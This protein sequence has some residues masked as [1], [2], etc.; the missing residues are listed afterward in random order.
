MSKKLLVLLV[1]LLPSQ[2]RSAEPSPLV[3]VSA[4]ITEKKADGRLTVAVKLRIGK[5]L[6]LFANP[7]GKERL[8]P[9]RIDIQGKRQL[10]DVKVTYPQGKEI[11][12]L[13]GSY[14]IYEGEVVITVQVRRARGDRGPLQV[15]V[16]Y[17]PRGMK[18][19]L[20]PEV[21]KITVQE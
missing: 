9:T 14:R 4:T 8:L 11:A 20:F 19:C 12:S 2:A 1:S 18:G 5:G 6:H 13:F 21:K 10:H 3:Q 17:Q 15:L 7:A 16:V